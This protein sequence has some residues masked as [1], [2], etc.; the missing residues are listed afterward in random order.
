M[1]FIHQ[2][3]RTAVDYGLNTHYA[4]PAPLG[5]TEETV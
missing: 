2:V 5:I 4:K 3:K 1:Q